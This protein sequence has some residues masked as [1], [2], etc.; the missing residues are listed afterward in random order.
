VTDRKRD[1]EWSLEEES[2]AGATS[3]GESDAHFADLVPFHDRNG[4][5][6]V[7]PFNLVTDHGR[8]PN[9]LGNEVPQGHV[10]IDAFDL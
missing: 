2:R 1:E 10:R 4:P 8:T 9:F 6:G 7:V 5:D 3:F